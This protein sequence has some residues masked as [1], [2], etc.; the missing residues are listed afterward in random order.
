M[1]TE[2]ADVIVVLILIKVVQLYLLLDRISLP[3]LQTLELGRSQRAHGLSIRVENDLCLFFAKHDV[4]FNDFVHRLLG[5]IGQLF[6]Q[7]LVLLVDGL[8]QLGFLELDEKL[9]Q[10][11]RLVARVIEVPTEAFLNIDHSHVVL[12]HLYRQLLRSHHLSQELYN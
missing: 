12:L 4:P 3:Q 2:C 5:D 6:F 8:H 10:N 7:L 9:L 11:V 1:V